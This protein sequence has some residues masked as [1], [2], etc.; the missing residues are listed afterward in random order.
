MAPKR[1]RDPESRLYRAVVSL[2]CPKISAVDLPVTVVCT[3][4]ASAEGAD[5]QRVFV[6]VRDLRSG[7]TDYVGL[8]VSRELVWQV[9]AAQAKETL[10]EAAG[11]SVAALLRKPFQQAK[12]THTVGQLDLAEGKVLADKA[13][14]PLNLL[15]QSRQYALPVTVCQ[16]FKL[17][18]SAP[19]SH[20]FRASELEFCSV[21]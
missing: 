10:A 13:A 21:Q 7:R 2:S 8:D 3:L 5:T 6:A 1:K 18:L 4:E 15:P 16:Q 12:V 14:A 20:L 19:V 11:V 17:S 9:G